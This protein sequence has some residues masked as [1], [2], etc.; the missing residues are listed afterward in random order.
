MRS[1]IS[2]D[3]ERIWIGAYSIISL[4]LDWQI[5]CGHRNFGQKVSM[6]VWLASWYGNLKMA[7]LLRV[8]FCIVAVEIDVS[9][10]R[11]LQQHDNFSSDNGFYKAILEV[12]LTY[13]WTISYLRISPWA[14][15]LKPFQLNANCVNNWFKGA[16][17][18][19]ES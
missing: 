19:T 18:C 1:T 10:L 2:R 3:R 13:L 14:T 17:L 9:H 15:K 8:L 6:Q 4:L 11:L 7:I 16:L 5:Q 12:G